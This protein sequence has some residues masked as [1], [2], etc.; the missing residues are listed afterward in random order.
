MEPTITKLVEKGV[1]NTWEKP[2]LDDVKEMEAP[3][4]KHVKFPSEEDDE[5]SLV[6]IG[7]RGPSAIT[8]VEEYVQTK[9]NYRY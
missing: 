8:Q 1:V 7:F 6:S 5:E 9:L 4:E 2:W 3:I